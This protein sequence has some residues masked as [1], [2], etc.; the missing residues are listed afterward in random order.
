MYKERFKND[1]FELFSFLIVSARNCV[2]EP[3][4]YG[5]LRLIDGVSRLIVILEKEGL[6][7]EFLLRMR[8]RIE[9]K[10]Y[11]VIT[12]KDEFTKF[13][14]DL[15]LDFADELKKRF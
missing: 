9:D 3:I 11:S 13:L 14:D 15:T 2:K 10:K 1:L 5:P 12:N 7:D 8:K 4:L 6:T